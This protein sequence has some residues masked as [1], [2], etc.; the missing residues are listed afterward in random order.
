MLVKIPEIVE[1]VPLKAMPVRL[2][3]LSLIQLNIVPATLLGLVIAIFAIA[4]PEQIV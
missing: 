4:V 1:P 2:E 3:L